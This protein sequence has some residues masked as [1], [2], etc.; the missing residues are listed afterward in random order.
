MKIDNIKLIDMTKLYDG[1]F[2]YNKD[3]TIELDF[4]NI[5]N[6]IENAIVKKDEPSK[7]DIKSNI[8]DLKKEINIIKA[9]QKN[10]FNSLD[11]KIDNQLLPIH[12][13]D[14][15]LKNDIKTLF[16]DIEDI[17]N[18]MEYKVHQND[19]DD[20]INDSSYFHDLDSKVEDLEN[21]HHNQVELDYVESIDNRL[22]RIECGLIGR[23][24]NS[25]KSVFNTLKSVRISIKTK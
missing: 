8:D 4:N 24:F 1:L 25:I 17:K 7:F 23:V 14:I 19:I 3:K 6:A 16:D 12:E 21:Y 5:V 11:K 13:K 22:K 10:D 15:D 18:D 9:N 2:G 20:A